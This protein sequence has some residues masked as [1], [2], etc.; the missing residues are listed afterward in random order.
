GAP[1]RIMARRQGDKLS[2]QVN[3]LQMVEFRD[4]FA[5]G[6]GQK[7]VFGVAWPAGVGIRRLLA[8]HEKL[9]PNPSRM[10]VADD[11]FLQGRFEEALDRY[12]EAAQSATAGDVREEALYKQGLCNLQ[13]NREEAA[14][15]MFEN[16]ASGF[17][18]AKRGAETRWYFLSDCQL[19]VLYFREKDGIEPAT[20]VLN[21]MKDYKLPFDQL[22]L[23][24]PPDVRRHVLSGTEIGSIG[25]NFH[26]RPEDH[27]SRTE[28]D[29]LASEVLEPPSHRWDYKYHHLM[30]AYMMAGRTS[31][32]LRTA[33]KSFKVFSYGGEV[34]DD[35]CWIR[36]L[37]G[38]VQEI[39][40]ALAAID[41]GPAS[42]ASHLVE[43]ARIHLAL[44]DVASAA[45]DLDAFLAK[46][47]DYH[48]W[49]AAC[50]L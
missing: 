12:G 20:A 34:L 32:A 50:L 24:M 8:T 35:Y 18:T 36:R 46:S 31:D 42:D 41:R 43:R 21:K 28:F 38:D 40:A 44:K 2:F 9:A 23:L 3:D 10:N 22:A 47:W 6:V 33:E 11:L 17:I 27:V 37:S 39:R 4:P 29:V 14:K 48:S 15:K 13:L 30:R 45:K 1:L 25:S 26:R 5:L 19:L 7:G 16:V 49:S